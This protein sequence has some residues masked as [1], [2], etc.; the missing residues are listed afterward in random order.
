[1][2]SDGSFETQ[3]SEFDQFLLSRIRN[4][5]KSACDPSKIG[6]NRGDVSTEIHTHEYKITICPEKDKFNILVNILKSRTIVK[7]A[8]LWERIN[9]S[10]SIKDSIKY[11][12][13]SRVISRHL[14]NVALFYC[15]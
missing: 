8:I 9:I 2:W 12:L 13:R 10:Y 7:L 15:Y 11:L 1:M 6:L 4:I 14:V 3:P 5:L